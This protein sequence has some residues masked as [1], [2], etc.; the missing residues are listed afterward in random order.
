MKR[1]T[2]KLVSYRST[3]KPGALTREAKREHLR[4]RAL[5][6]RTVEDLRNIVVAILEDIS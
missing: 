3:T 5:E 4:R 1:P 6:A 2:T